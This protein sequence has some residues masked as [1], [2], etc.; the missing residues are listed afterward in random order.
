[1]QRTGISQAIGQVRISVLNVR[2]NSLR[3]HYTLYRRGIDT[4]PNPKC[5]NAKFLFD[6]I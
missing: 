5:T 6:Y 2:W 4:A 3:A 1:M